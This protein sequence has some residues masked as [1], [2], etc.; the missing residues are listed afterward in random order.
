MG[1][2]AKFESYAESGANPWP[3]TDVDPKE[4]STREYI[5]A[6]AHAIYSLYLNDKTGTRYFDYKRFENLRWYGRG[7]QSEDRYKPHF[8]NADFNGTDDIDGEGND[9]R[10]TT[11]N[12]KFNR[13]GFY[14]IRYDI[15]SPAKKINSQIHGHL[16][17]IDY[18][19]LTKRIDSNSGD[20]EENA[21]WDLWTEAKE[22]DFLDAFKQNA[23]I[24]LN[25][26]EFLPQN[27]MELEIYEA[28]GGFKPNYIKA[29]QKLIAHTLDI[30]KYQDIKKKHIDD[31]I[32]TNVIFMKDYFDE[33]SGK[34]KQRYVDPEN[35][36]IEYSK[37]ADFRNSEFAAEWRYVPIH[38]VRKAILKEYPDSTEEDIVGI[39]KIYQG[40]DNNPSEE[41]WNSR[42]GYNRGTGTWY[43]DYRVCL[44]DF[45]WIDIDKE[46]IK[47]KQKDNGPEREYKGKYGEVKKN[48]RVNYKKNRYKGTWVIGTNYVYEYGLDFDQTR[49]EKAEV[50][51]TYHGFK[52]PGKSLTEQLIPIYDQ[53]QLT[54]L[55]L[56]N[57]LATEFDNIMAMDFRMLSNITD[58]Q[59][60]SFGLED[61][62]QMMRDMKIL[63]YMGTPVGQG[64]KGGAV[65]PLH[66]IEG[67]MMDG[68][69]K[70]ILMLNTQ[71]GLVEQLTGLSSAALGVTPNP[72]QPVGTQEMAVNATMKSLKPMI[73]AIFSLKEMTA[74]NVILRIQLGLKYNKDFNTVYQPVVGDTDLE[75]LKIA[76]HTSAQYGIVLKA[77]PDEKKKAELYEAVT[78][79]VQ[80]QAISLAQELWI[81]S[82][83]DDGEDLIEISQ[84]LDYMMA[85]T[86]QETQAAN[87]SAAVQQQQQAQQL[88]AMR[89][90]A[91]QSK[92]QFEYKKIIDEERVKGEEE[93]KNLI[94]QRNLEFINSVEEAAALEQGMLTES[95][96]Q[97]NA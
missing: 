14:N 40:Y 81:K 19:I 15:V 56:Q 37:Y 31:L 41:E 64:Y 91:E 76:E 93:R 87:Q 96:Q 51:L 86:R 1:G 35:M 29:M 18:R 52:I 26:P 72:N 92:Q 6:V 67:G 4:K 65:V 95:N 61:L 55:K 22:K 42:F 85:K 46:Y 39:A 30:S 43:S 21:K 36:I 38:E 97:Q 50:T 83:I 10:E 12:K 78:K 11:N 74:K 48:T 94:L 17:D 54:W 28:A 79:A 3:N 16:D 9:I 23:G 75:L 82:A 90:Q 33:E 32:D 24:P 59:G 77:M 49:P 8:G 63:P 27:E 47:V 70:Y 66:K 89:Q 60:N 84:Q 69:N 53:V 58:G 71:L 25:E 44:L 80:F 20:E 62:I 57:A 73:S 34:V 88:E 5:I 2:I 45:E 68:F 7:E 13:E